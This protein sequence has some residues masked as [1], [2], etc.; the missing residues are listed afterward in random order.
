MK[1]RHISIAAAAA[2]FSDAIEARDFKE[3]FMGPGRIECFNGECD[4]SVNASL[5]CGDPCHTYTQSNV[6]EYT[7]A[8]IS[9]V[10]GEVKDDRGSLCYY[11]NAT[12]I[13]TEYWLDPWP[14]KIEEGCRALCRGCTFHP[15]ATFS[16]PGLL[17]CTA[18]NCYNYSYGEPYNYCNSEVQDASEEWGE[19]SVLLDGSNDAEV[20]QGFNN[21]TTTEPIMIGKRCSLDCSGCTFELQETANTHRMKGLRRT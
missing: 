4:F 6:F 7:F 17:N 14:L 11:L 13:S 10:S 1:Y 21:I 19:L 20:F 2:T 16:G 18:G 15:T 12:H 9:T 3:S 5:G 8:D